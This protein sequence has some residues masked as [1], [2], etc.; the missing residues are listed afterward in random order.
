M[1]T[2]KGSGGHRTRNTHCNL[3][4]GQKR[5]PTNRR[6]R[7]SF[8]ASWT[9]TVRAGPNFISPAGGDDATMPLCKQTDDRHL[10]GSQ[11]C[12]PD[13]SQIVMVSEP[14][15]FLLLDLSMPKHK[16]GFASVRGLDQFAYQNEAQ[17]ERLRLRRH[18]KNFSVK[19]YFRRS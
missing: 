13:L 11:Q 5:G 18:P 7:R 4:A 10:D 12:D 16:C 8:K 9:R 15:T 1:V 2:N 14:S 19:G 6:N 3:K 17:P